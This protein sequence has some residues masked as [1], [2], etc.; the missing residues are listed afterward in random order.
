MLTA[1][2]AGGAGILV[3]VHQGRRGHPVVL[4][5]RHRDELLRA[6]DGIGLRGLLRAHPA[7]VVEW[8]T[9]D[10]AVLED[11]DTPADY[12]R[13]RRSRPPDPPDLAGAGSTPA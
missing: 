2:R 1:F 11:L 12:A 9:D 8:V 5:A 10:A 3:P 6:H 13:A 7:D 4:A